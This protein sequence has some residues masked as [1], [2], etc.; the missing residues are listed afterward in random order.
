LI[1]IIIGL[2]TLKY[3]KKEIHFLTIQRCIDI[4]RKILRKQQSYEEKETEKSIIKKLSV[5]TL[6]HLGL[7]NE[8]LFYMK[9]GYLPKK[10][11]KDWLFDMI[12]FVPIYVVSGKCPI[13]EDRIRKSKEIKQFI[14]SSLPKEKNY[15]K[16]LKDIKLFGKINYVFK[17]DKKFYERLKG[18]NGKIEFNEK[19]KKRLVNYFLRNIRHTMFCRR[20]LFK[21]QK[22]NGI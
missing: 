7:I 9:K 11:S 8:E 17:I 16:Y 4:H 22:K 1:S 12:E 20:R 18:E 2:I 14:N 13:N 10:L 21:E 5:L 3:Q 6:D 19:N 15:E